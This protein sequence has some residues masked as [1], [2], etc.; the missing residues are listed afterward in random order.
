MTVELSD[1]PLMPRQALEALTA[2]MQTSRCYLEYGM[3]GTT[4]LACR[5]GVPSII[6]VESKREW[7]DAV[8]Q[9]LNGTACAAHL[10]HVDIGKTKAW[11]YPANNDHWQAYHRYPLA[12]WGC[13]RDHAVEPDVV[14]VDGRF[15]VACFLAS[16][17]HAN[18]GTTV[19]FDDYL[20]RPHYTAVERFLRPERC[21]GRCAVF[22]V[23]ANLPR[24]EIWRE[25][26][27]AVADAR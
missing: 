22:S 13:A 14:L 7:R 8:E 15:R 10:L 18:P 11:G 6:S 17:I 25:I 16:L 12:P 20:D 3:G 26:L 23:P 19:F 9:R 27:S 2:A 4:L 5:L 21:V 1:T 24:D